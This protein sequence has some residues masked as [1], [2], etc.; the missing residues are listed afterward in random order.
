MAYELDIGALAGPLAQ[1]GTCL[2]YSSINSNLRSFLLMLFCNKVSEKSSEDQ[3]LW[4]DIESSYY[5]I[6][7]VLYL[8]VNFYI[9][10]YYY[11]IHWLFFFRFVFRLPRDHVQRQLPN[12]KGRNSRKW[13]RLYNSRQSCMGKVAILV[14]C[15]RWCIFAHSVGQLV[16]YPCQ[17]SFAKAVLKASLKLC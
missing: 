11:F 6:N 8:N 7:F 5:R 14:L 17:K 9:T 10:H 13:C 3:R 16:G 12:H 4:I 2:M 15:E 1:N